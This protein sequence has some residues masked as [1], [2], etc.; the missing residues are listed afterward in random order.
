[1][2]KLPDVSLGQ[3]GH[4]FVSSQDTNYIRLYDV[5]I[6][7]RFD[8]T[9]LRQRLRKSASPE[10]KVARTHKGLENPGANSR[11]RA[12]FHQSLSV[13][14]AKKPLQRHKNRGEKDT[15]QTE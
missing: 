2:E 14:F 10:L 6:Y 1:M 5:G 11:E 7:T 8:R 3:I 15:S 4:L 9:V 12:P 13:P